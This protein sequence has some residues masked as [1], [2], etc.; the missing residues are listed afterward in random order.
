MNQPSHSRVWALLLA[1]VIAAAALL[2]VLPLETSATPQAN[3]I[4]SSK[5]ASQYFVRPNKL[6]TYT[7][8]VRNTGAPATGVVV[9]DTPPLGTIPVTCTVTTGICQPVSGQIWNGDIGS[10]S[11]VTITY[12]VTTF[13]STLN[14]P[15]V[16]TAQIGPDV[17]VTAKSVLNPLLLYLPLIRKS[18]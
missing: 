13:G 2:L 3:F 6:L 5:T 12:V 18:P 9:T 15:L 17:A 7:I 8:V 16:N 1:V 11:A 4:T 14:W 10:N